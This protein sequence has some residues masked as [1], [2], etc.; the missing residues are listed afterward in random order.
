[1]YLTLFWL[2]WQGFYRNGYCTHVFT[3]IWPGFTVFGNSAGAIVALEIHI[4]YPERFQKV[5]A[6]EPPIVLLLPDTAKRLAFFDEVYNTYRKDGIPK[7]MRQF[8]SVIA[9]KGDQQLIKRYMT[10]QANEHTRA[11]VTC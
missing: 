7:A 8:A 10:Q 5:V 1:L 6:H 9:G 2:F 4:H 3:I 11:N